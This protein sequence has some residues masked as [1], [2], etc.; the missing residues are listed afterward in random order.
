MRMIEH[1]NKDNSGDQLFATKQ[2][3]ASV[4]A[5]NRVVSTKLNFDF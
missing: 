4:M 5:H 3:S 1:K 2:P